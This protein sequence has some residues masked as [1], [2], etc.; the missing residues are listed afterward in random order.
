MAKAF[1]LFI[2]IIH[3]LKYGIKVALMERSK[4]E[5]EKMVKTLN[6]QIKTECLTLASMIILTTSDTD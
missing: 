3:L 6:A 1:Y 5:V 2:R 4:Y